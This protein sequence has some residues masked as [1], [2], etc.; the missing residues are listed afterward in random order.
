MYNAKTYGIA[1]I[2]LY[3]QNFK[4]RKATKREFLS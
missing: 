3:G 4:M 1:R 2:Q